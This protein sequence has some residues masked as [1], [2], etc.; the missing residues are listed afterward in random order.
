M[1]GGFGPLQGVKIIEMPAVGPLQLLGT[2][3]ADL[4]A[5]VLR[6][7]RPA[8]MEKRRDSGVHTHNRAAVVLDLKKPESV[9]LLLQMAKASDVLVEGF[10]PGV[11]ERL[12]LGPDACL[13]AN[14]RLIYGRMTGWGQQGP[15]ASAPGH[16]INYLALSGAL[17]AI[18]TPD[19]PVAP[20]NLLADYGGGGM[21]MAMG[22]LA[23]LVERQSSGRGQVIDAAMLDGVGLLMSMVYEVFERGGWRNQRGANLL[24]GAAPFYR[25]YRC[26]D[27][28]WLAVGCTEMKFRA[29]LGGAIGVPELGEPGSSHPAAWP[30]LCARLE[31][32]FATR[33]RDDWVRRLGDLETCVS[34][35]LDLEEAPQHPHAQARDGFLR[36]SLGWTPAP[37]PRFSRTPPERASPP[38]LAEVLAAF[39][40]GAAAVPPEA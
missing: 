13:A 14:P 1:S 25:C 27:G 39:G 22:V 7:E 12:G 5:T 29:N 16:D 35:V 37:A 30:G 6:I 3:F 31:A 34:P 17:A 23:A 38:D 40:V 32:V 15:L 21:L 18:G 2:I 10:R 8:G 9:A 26:A 28:R 33:G 36:D 4:G 19:Q 11:M 24:D 20:L